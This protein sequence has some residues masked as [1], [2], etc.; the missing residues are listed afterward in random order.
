MPGSDAPQ[1]GL[2]ERKK[3]HT[4]ELI[5]ET[6]RGLFSERGFERVTVA[7]IARAADVSEQTV[8]NY[9]PTKE[10][11]VYWRLGSFEEELLAT[12]REREPG[13]PALAAFRRFLLAQRGLMGKSDPEARERL[14][15]LTRMISESPALLAREQQIFA[16]YTAS[17]AALIAGEQGSDG[18]E[19]WVS[20][21]AMMGAH[22]ALV[23]YTR[24]RVLEGAG[25]PRLA[26]EVRAQA[27]QALG[28]LERGF[29]DYAIKAGAR[30][31]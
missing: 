4:R 17:L 14:A 15:A 9:F 11:L 28:R 23:G 25:Q 2:R 24:R 18:I 12:I 19:P 8:F 16:G 7:E 3:Q 31:P 26:R 22:R 30:E 6:A 5:A 20:A 27:E 21:N 13:E 10:D 29:G 1:L